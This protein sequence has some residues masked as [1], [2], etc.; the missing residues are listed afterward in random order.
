MGFDVKKIAA[1]QVDATARWHREPIDNPYSGH[2]SLACEQHR[3]N[4]ELWHQEDAARDE[5]ASDATIAQVKRNI[6]RLNQRRNDWIEKLDDHLTDSLETAAAPQLADA[7]QN[8]ETPGSIV[9]RM[10]IM[11]L[12]IYHLEEQL[13]RTDVDSQHVE[14]VSR[15]LAVCRLQRTDLQLCLT[16]LLDDIAAGRKRHRT[17]RQFK[18][19]NDPAMNPYL[20][21]ARR[22]A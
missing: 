19:Y 22:A 15:R 9:D 8:S 3:F 16:Q 20:Y 13:H 2:L 21:A 17:Y 1:M 11:A 4:Y 5:H 18:M 12:R 14:K 6:D 10:S 7:P